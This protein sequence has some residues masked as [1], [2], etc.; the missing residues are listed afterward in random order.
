MGKEMTV[1][2]FNLRDALF[3]CPN[4]SLLANGLISEIYRPGR[5]R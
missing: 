2:H 1:N 5:A 3:K 4:I